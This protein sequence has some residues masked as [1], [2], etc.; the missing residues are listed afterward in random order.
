MRATSAH[1]RTLPAIPN[2]YTNDRRDRIR[3]QVPAPA[4]DRTDRPPRTD[5]PPHAMEY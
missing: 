2:R 1:F 3:P 5:L 4:P